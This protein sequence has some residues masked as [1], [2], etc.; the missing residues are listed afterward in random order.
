M[1]PLCAKPAQRPPL[2]D[3]RL[4]HAQRGETYE[5]SDVR[6]LDRKWE[7][8]EKRFRAGGGQGRDGKVSERAREEEAS[9]V[10][11]RNNQNKKLQ[12]TDCRRRAFVHSRRPLF[13]G[14]HGR[15]QRPAPACELGRVVQEEV[16]LFR[17]CRFFRREERRA[18]VA[19]SA[20]TTTLGRRKEKNSAKENLS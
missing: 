1:P 2:A 5:P 6:F 20:S 19:M 17:H 4:V 10:F 13:Q 7:R 11:N 14:D 18:D 12:L 15:R 3:V 8:R 9:E 16:G